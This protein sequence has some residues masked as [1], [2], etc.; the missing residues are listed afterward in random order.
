VVTGDGDTARTSISPETHRLVR[1]HFVKDGQEF[2]MAFLR[3]AKLLE[4]LGAGDFM[5]L[6][7]LEL[8]I[9]GRARV[10]AVEPCPTVEEGIGRVV[11]GAF[12][13]QSCDIRL[14]KVHGLAAPMEITGNHP[15]FSEDRLGFVRANELRPGER[16]RTRDGVAVVESVSHDPGRWD[17]FN[18][19]VESAHQYYVTERHV[20]VHNANGVTGISVNGTPLAGYGATGEEVR[21]AAS[22]IR[23]Y[24]E[25]GYT[26]EPSPTSDLRLVSEDGTKSVRFDLTTGDP[27]GPHINIETW[28]PRNLFP[29]DERMILTGNEHVFLLP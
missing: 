8:E 17:V 26:I 6:S 18:L 14:V 4:G 25:E 10:L 2:N 13:G 12:S 19:E 7:V 27:R 16:L 21:D 9:R 5:E 3:P 1:L 20:L 24:L 22:V 23:R 15:V 28:Q 29:G 11:T